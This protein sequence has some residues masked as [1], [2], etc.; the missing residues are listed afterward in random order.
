MKVSIQQLVYKI[1][2]AVVIYNSG[3]LAIDSIAFFTRLVMVISF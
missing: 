3:Q 2:T 1:C